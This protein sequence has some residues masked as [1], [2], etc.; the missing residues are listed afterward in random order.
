MKN[1]SFGRQLGFLSRR[2]DDPRRMQLRDGGYRDAYERRG[3]SDDIAEIG[4]D[5]TK[6]RRLVDGAAM[7]DIVALYMQPHMQKIQFLH[8]REYPLRPILRLPE[9]MIPDCPFSEVV[10]GRRSSRNFDG[11]PIA[12]AAMSALLFSACGETE[13]MIADFGDGDEG[14]VS[15]RSI[16]SGGGL[17]PTRVFAAVVQPGELAPG[18]YHFDAP[19]H[20]L[21]F[22][23]AVV[24]PRHGQVDP[25]LSDTSGRG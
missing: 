2:L 4:H 6:L 13:R 14:Y 19:S 24:R 10:R 23:Q 15:L 16:P 11:G 22:C 8:D 18:I 3:E 1:E 21:E 20:T 25:R 5:L 9:P 12:L 7:R 17:H